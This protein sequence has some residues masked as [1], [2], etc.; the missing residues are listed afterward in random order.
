MELWD[1]Y[2]YG[3]AVGGGEMPTEE[4]RRWFMD[5]SQKCLDPRALAHLAK[6]GM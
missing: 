2:T 6:F 1:E 4:F 5:D 3:L